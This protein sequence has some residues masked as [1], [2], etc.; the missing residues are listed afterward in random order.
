[1]LPAPNSK[2][3]LMTPT[4][5][6]VPLPKDQSKGKELRRENV[7]ETE[8]QLNIGNPYRFVYHLGSTRSTVVQIHM[9][10]Q[11][12]F[13]ESAA[14][15]RSRILSLPKE[16]PFCWYVPVPNIFSQHWP[17]CDS[18]GKHDCVPGKKTQG[19]SPRS[20]DWG[21]DAQ[22]PPVG[23]APVDHNVQ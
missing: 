12:T 21:I 19:I 11:S 4:S 6:S 7:I 16:S 14:N 23:D 5:P 8:T 3:G 1:M 20:R 10:L 17:L 15:T 13:T 2:P 22:H 9:V 18:Q